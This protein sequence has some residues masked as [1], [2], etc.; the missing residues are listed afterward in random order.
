MNNQ[1]NNLIL[2]AIFFIA[3]G[4]LLLS[5]GIFPF[6]FTTTAWITTYIFFFLCS[7]YLGIRY[8]KKATATDQK[9]FF[10]FHPLTIATFFAYLLVLTSSVAFIGSIITLFNLTL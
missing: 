5:P 8:I 7:V 9:K 10:I 2:S 1:N 3:G 4:A 6:F